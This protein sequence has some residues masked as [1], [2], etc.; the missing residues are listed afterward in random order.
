MHRRNLTK[1]E[2]KSRKTFR[3]RILFILSIAGVLY[4]AIPLFLGDM[5]IV[6]YFGMLKTHHRISKEIQALSEG[7]RE[8]EREVNA[9]RSDPYMIEKIARKELGLV[10]EGELIYKIRIKDR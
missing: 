2:L 3:K 5:G 4:L 1:A 7:N 9:L 10:R 6:K 8:L